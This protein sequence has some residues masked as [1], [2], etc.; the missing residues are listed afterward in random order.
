MN[1]YSFEERER[2][3]L[4]P[5]T[6]DDYGV[7]VPSHRDKIPP[8]TFTQLVVFDTLQSQGTFNPHKR[9]FKPHCRLSPVP[10]KYSV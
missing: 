2:G 8:V 6:L 9:K 10:Y 1:A 7:S 5:E 4:L 3:L